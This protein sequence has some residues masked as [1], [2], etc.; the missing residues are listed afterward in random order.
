MHQFYPYGQD[1]TCFPA[2]ASI[3]GLSRATADQQWIIEA[4]KEKLI[5]PTPEKLGLAN[6]TPHFTDI[7][8][9]E[10]T[11]QAPRKYTPKMLQTT[12][13]EVHRMLDEGI[14]ESSDSPWRSC[15]VLVPN[16]CDM[17][18]FFMNYRQ[19]NK[20]TKAIACPLN[21]MDDILDKLSSAKYISKLDLNHRIF[22]Y[23]GEDFSTSS[24]YHM[25]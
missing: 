8:G 22:Q 3:R 1:P 10:P 17:F 11:R 20:T 5:P 9:N 2:L 4:L 19:V 23:Q 14:I 25:G 15:P 13:A 12:W 16:T 24:R 21:N 6:V 18:R 7:Q